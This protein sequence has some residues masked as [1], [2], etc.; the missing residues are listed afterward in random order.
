MPHM[1]DK[2]ETDI[3]SLSSILNEFCKDL[4]LILLS[5]FILTLP[6]WGIMR[7]ETTFSVYVKKLGYYTRYQGTKD[8]GCYLKKT[9]GH[10]KY[11]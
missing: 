1:T 9:R 2:A 10:N 6:T 7:T 3:L 11:E 8:K 5:M 4:K